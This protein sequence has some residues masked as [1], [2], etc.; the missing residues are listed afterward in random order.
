MEAPGQGLSAVGM[1]LI[2][3]SLAAAAY[4]MELLSV[5][6]TSSKRANFVDEMHLYISISDSTKLGDT[7]RS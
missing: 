5:K 6:S 7:I 3:S 2:S 1:I 4:W